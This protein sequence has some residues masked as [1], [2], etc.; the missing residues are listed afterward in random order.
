MYLYVKYLY[1]IYALCMFNYVVYFFPPDPDN[2]R[3]AFSRPIR[4]GQVARPGGVGCHGY[5]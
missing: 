5:V 4:E 1:C 3:E 2:G